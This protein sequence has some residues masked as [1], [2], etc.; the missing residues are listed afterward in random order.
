M[1]LGIPYELWDKP[2]AEVTIMQRQC[3]K[4]VEDFEE[5]IEEWYYH[6]QDLDISKYICKDRILPKNDLGM[7][8]LFV[9]EVP[10]QVYGKMNN[11]VFLRN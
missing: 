2:S 8:S 10:S 4:M 1:E 6:H 9:I 5:D 11:L 7:C 3:Y